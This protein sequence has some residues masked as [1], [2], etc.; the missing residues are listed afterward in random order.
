[1]HLFVVMGLR[2]GRRWAT[3]A[4]VLLSSV[5]AIASI[6]LGATAGA[7]AIREPNYALSLIGAAL[8]AT[9]AAVGYT[10]AAV[11]LMRELGSG[12]AS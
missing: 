10:L 4:G 7:S 2:D 5:L 3:S 8:L 9:V 11:A 6:A 12:S 1:M